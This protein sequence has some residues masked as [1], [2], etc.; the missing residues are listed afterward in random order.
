MVP[1]TGYLSWFIPGPISFC[2]AN[3]DTPTSTQTLLYLANADLDT[4][5]GR[6]SPWSIEVFFL[7]PLSRAG[8]SAQ[9]SLVA[10]HVR[11]MGCAASASSARFPRGESA[12]RFSKV[13]P[14]DAPA[15]V[16]PVARALVSSDQPRVNDREVLASLTELKEHDLQLPQTFQD[17]PG[18]ALLA[19]PDILFAIS[20][21]DQIYY[22]DSTLA[23]YRSWEPSMEPRPLGQPLPPGPQ[24]H[25]E[26]MHRVLRLARSARRH[27]RAFKV[28]LGRDE[29]SDEE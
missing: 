29:D 21:E 11:P 7:S 22:D 19:A 1:V 20:S 5:D 15:P 27:P 4:S 18:E 23:T 6:S 2:L 3:Q 24:E 26:N 12:I 13:L 10:S 14:S 9:A 8:S 28:V 25:L 16:R 17:V